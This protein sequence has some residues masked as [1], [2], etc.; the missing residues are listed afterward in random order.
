MRKAIILSL[1]VFIIAQCTNRSS[2]SA[3]DKNG[4]GKSLNYYT[5]PNDEWIKSGPTV[6]L[7]HGWGSNGQDLLNLKTRLS[8]H[9]NYLSVDAP[10]I[11]GENE[12]SWFE[13]QFDEIQVAN[14]NLDEL[15]Q[16]I[17]RLHE[18]IEWYKTQNN[19]TSNDIVLFGF[20]QGA[21]MALELAIHYPDAVSAIMVISG[22]FG[23]ERSEGESLPDK[24]CNIEIFQAHGKYDK[25]VPLKSAKD[26]RRHL[27]HCRN[28]TF[29]SY[30]MEHEVK[31]IMLRDLRRWMN[32]RKRHQNS[33][34]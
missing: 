7:L 1:L 24:M 16:S 29:K 31:P 21:T 11:M 14:F 17:N 34:R 3:H 22:M 28:Y 26:V 20:S 27:K 12:F 8:K 5:D 23:R 4:P 13:I 10:F 15:K 25:V 33:Q 19:L 2:Q 6:I 9:Y 32:L 18:F 30:K